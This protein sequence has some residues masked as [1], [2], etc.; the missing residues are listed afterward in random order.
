[1]SDFL[2]LS[3]EGCPIRISYK[4]IM[5][6]NALH[7]I[8]ARRGLG[9]DVIGVNCIFP[10]W[11]NGGTMAPQIGRLGVVVADATAQKRGTAHEL[12]GLVRSPRGF[13]IEIVAVSLYLLVPLPAD[14][15]V[16]VAVPQ[17]VFRVCDSAFAFLTRA[18]VGLDQAS[19]EET[20]EGPDAASQ[21]GAQRSPG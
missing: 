8:A 9:D 4:K 10:N 15:R 17:D 2:R 21:E 7:S 19:P 18:H 16:G 5:I 13:T 6:A 12:P 3:E 11:I 1:M 14:A 20:V